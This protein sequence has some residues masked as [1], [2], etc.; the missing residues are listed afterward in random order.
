MNKLGLG[1]AEE[2]KIKVANICWIM[3]KARE[4]QKNIYFCFINYLKVFEYVDHR[5]L[6]KIL[7]ELRIRDHITCLLREPSM[8][9]KKQQLE[10]DMEQL[11]GQ[12]WE[13]STTS[14][15]VVTFLFELY[16]EYIM[17][18]A[19]L[20]ESQAGIKIAENNINNLRYADDTTL[21]VKEE[22]KSL[23][24]RVKEE[25]KKVVLKL[26]IQKNKIM[27]SGP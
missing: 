26:N 3:E 23:L 11:T 1:K 22:L 12:N 27:T 24:M 19:G 21:M 17:L 25:S 5:K 16:S 13:R 9:A 20:D 18:N 8:W 15:C 2:S 14:L 7:K 6:W 10:L 4:F